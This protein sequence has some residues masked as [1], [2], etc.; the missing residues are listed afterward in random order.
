MARTPTDKRKYPAAIVAARS[1]NHPCAIALKDD[2]DARKR[3]DDTMVETALLLVSTG[4]SLKQ[5]AAELGVSTGA[6]KQ[7]RF[8]D[9]EGFGERL[10]KAYAD[11]AHT[12]KDTVLEVAYSKEYTAAEKKV[13]IEALQ[14]TAKVDNRNRYGD[15]VAIDQRQVVINL[16]PEMDGI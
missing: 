4:M 15:K 1:S 5:V 8:D 9:R 14:W 7:R 12:L 16:P 10:D 2:G 13:I 11:R 6:I 3:F